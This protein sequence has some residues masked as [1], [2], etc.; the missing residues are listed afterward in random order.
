MI[1]KPYELVANPDGRQ[2]I[3]ER[4]R[5]IK[6]V[7]YV[8]VPYGTYGTDYVGYDPVTLVQ[9]NPGWSVA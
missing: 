3:L 4:H 1:E 7:L 9:M 2:H 8:W 5:R 6:G